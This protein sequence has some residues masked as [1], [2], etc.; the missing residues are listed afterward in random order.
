MLGKG[1]RELVERLE[2]TRSDTK[3]LY[4]SGYT[5]NAI[6]HHGILEKGLSFIQKPFTSHGLTKKVREAM[7]D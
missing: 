5:D 2:K 7:G 1:G 3:I 4:M 6:V